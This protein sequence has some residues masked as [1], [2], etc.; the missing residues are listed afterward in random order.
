MKKIENFSFHE[1][2]N[3][4]VNNSTTWQPEEF[5]AEKE[6]LMRSGIHVGGSYI[7]ANARIV[8]SLSGAARA[9]LYDVLRAHSLVFRL[10]ARRIENCV[11]KVRLATETSFVDSQWV[12]ETGTINPVSDPTWTNEELVPM[13]LYST[14]PV[15]EAILKLNGPAFESYMYNAIMRSQAEA[16]DN[17][18]INGDGLT[19][20]LGLLN[21]PDITQDD[22]G[23]NGQALTLA[24]VIKAEEIATPNF[25][26]A[27]YLRYSYLMN[28]ATKRKLKQT[29]KVVDGDT[30][31]MAS[32]FLNGHNAAISEHMPGNIA[33]GTGTNL[34]AL[35][36]GNFHD[37]VCLHWGGFD[38]I[39]DRFTQAL[40]GIT[41][42]HVSSFMNLKVVRPELFHVTNGI[43][44]A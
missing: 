38:I 27:E 32:N 18:F 6:Q 34:S 24:D 25:Y 31:I 4:K 21:N 35:V 39:V 14:V 33:L 37:V 41:R 40:Q 29:P 26:D 1:I 36:F 2:I 3:E 13:R 22:L 15:S 11:S 43:I 20:P 30:M 7:G 16:L 10:G 19:S 5:K 28:A 12:T 23:A 17:A 42:V 44:T 8:D 9:T